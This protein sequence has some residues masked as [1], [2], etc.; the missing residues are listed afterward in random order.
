MR[1]VF[2]YGRTSNVGNFYMRLINADNI[3]HCCSGPLVEE[4]VT[5]T[6]SDGVPTLMQNIRTCRLV[7]VDGSCLQVTVD[8][9][10]LAG[11]L[12]E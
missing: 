12:G 4:A 5:F 3:A 6:E 2:L 10:T 7:F 9:N 8:L 11:M 1:P